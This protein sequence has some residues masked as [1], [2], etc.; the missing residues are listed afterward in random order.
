MGILRQTAL[1]MV[2]T[3]QQNFSA[4]V[5]TGLLRNKIGCHLWILATVLLP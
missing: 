1:N 2:R 5:S 4:D 3:V